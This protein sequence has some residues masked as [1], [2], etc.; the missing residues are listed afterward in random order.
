MIVKRFIPGILLVAIIGLMLVACGRDGGPTES[1][2]TIY[3]YGMQGCEEPPCPVILWN[4]AGA[5]P[6]GGEQIGEMPHGT[7]LDAY[8]IKEYFG[9][10]YYFVEYKGQRG[11]VAGNSVSK[12]EPTCE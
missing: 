9:V 3:A 7:E 11:W 4:K 1:I 10:K 12:I 6:A 2:M 8:E 5:R